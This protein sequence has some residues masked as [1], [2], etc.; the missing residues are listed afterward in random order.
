MTAEKKEMAA[1]GW[2]PKVMWRNA[3]HFMKKKMLLLI[4]EKSY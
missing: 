4:I 3:Y 2:T 1:R